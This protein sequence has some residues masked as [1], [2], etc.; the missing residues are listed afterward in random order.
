MGDR[1]GSSRRNRRDAAYADDRQAVKELVGQLGQ[2]DEPAR[3]FESHAR[4]FG[5]PV[6]LLPAPDKAPPP[7]ELR[8]DRLRQGV[9]EGA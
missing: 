8:I 3:C 6:P 4:F 2:R 5:V 1:A 7:V 9:L